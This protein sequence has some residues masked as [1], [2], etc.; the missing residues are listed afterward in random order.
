MTVAELIE[1]L[2][3]LPQDAEV[4]VP[5]ESD[6]ERVAYVG[7]H[8]SYPK[9]RNASRYSGSVKLRWD[10]ETDEDIADAGLRPGPVVVMLSANAK[11]EVL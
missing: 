7:A 5:L 1:R 3:A 9:E 6:F 11:P 8:A 10:W 2:K 4:V